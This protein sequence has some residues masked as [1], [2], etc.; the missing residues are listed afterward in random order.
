MRLAD[1]KSPERQD[2]ARLEAAALDGSMGS[3]SHS[4]RRFLFNSAAVANSPEPTHS[5]IRGL[6][7]GSNPTLS[8]SFFN[9]AVILR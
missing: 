3:E 1:P 9:P 8:A 6:Q 7:C 2:R 4:L 5:R